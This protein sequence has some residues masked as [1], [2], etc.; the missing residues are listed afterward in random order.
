[1]AEKNDFIG[2]EYKEVQAK[3]GLTS[4]YVDGYENF[5]WNLE[6]TENP[7]GKIDTVVLKFK[8]NRKIC[9]KMELTRLQ[10]QF[11]A[12]L[13]EI[14]M[15]EASKQSNA[16]MAA[17]TVGVIGTAFMAGSVFA[18]TSNMIALCIVLAIPAFIGWITPYFIYKSILQKRTEHVT[19]LIDGKYDEL[20]EVCQR[21]HN[22]L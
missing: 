20:Y 3:R 14:R 15:M 4:V 8:R 10:R 21:G 18:I 12:I 13:N 6:S 17:C 16:T 1:M 22:L 19:P 7:I 2:Y 5:G 9:N 11:D